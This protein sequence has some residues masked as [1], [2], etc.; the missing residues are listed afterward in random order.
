MGSEGVFRSPVHR[1][2][3]ITRVNDLIRVV[4]LYTK[5]LS[6]MRL[7]NIVGLRVCINL[8][9]KNIILIKIYLLPNIPHI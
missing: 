5:L 3:R 7:S 1:N 2:V 8:K 9:Y 4:A 6:G